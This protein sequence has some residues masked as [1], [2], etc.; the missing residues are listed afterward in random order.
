MAR[1][2]DWQQTAHTLRPSLQPMSSR[3]HR[4]A[5]CS[6]SRWFVMRDV[7]SGEGTVLMQPR[8][9]LS[10]LRRPMKASEIRRARGVFREDV[11]PP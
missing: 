2:H 1:G 4:A 5:S 9:A 10:F 7:H 8:W 11:G 3:G 6:S